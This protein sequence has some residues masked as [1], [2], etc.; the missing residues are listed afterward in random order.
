MMNR[1]PQLLD[2]S[3]HWSASRLMGEK[4]A[5]KDEQSS[6]LSAALPASRTASIIHHPSTGIG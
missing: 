1:K 3:F 5:N 6:T 4:R 2:E